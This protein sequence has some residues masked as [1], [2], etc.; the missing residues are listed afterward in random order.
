MEVQPLLYHRPIKLSSQAKLFE[1][2]NRSRAQNLKHVRNLSIQLTDVDMTLRSSSE[3]SQSQHQHQ[4]QHSPSPPQ[5]Q[6][7]HHQAPSAWSL[8]EDELAYFDAALRSLPSLTEITIIPPRAMHSQLLR[9][10]YLS[11]LALIPRVHPC[12]KLLVVHDEEESVLKAVKILQNLPRVVFKN[13]PSVVTRGSGDLGVK[14]K[15][16][17]SPPLVRSPREKVTKIKVEVER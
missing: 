2:V 17:S 13:S 8:Y 4:H 5:Q 15:K 9:G 16:A 10:M 6:A 14:I 7:Y 1:W 3:R 12:L 11:I